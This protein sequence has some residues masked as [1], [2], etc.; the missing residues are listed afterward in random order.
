MPLEYFLSIGESVLSVDWPRKG[1]LVT[2][3]NPLEGVG[4]RGKK[5]E[6]CWNPAI[7]CALFGARGALKNL[8]QP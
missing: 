5:E 4:G 1:C 3:Q 8:D 6:Y 2:V 7:T